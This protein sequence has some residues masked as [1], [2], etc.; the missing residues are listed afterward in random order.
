MTIPTTKN[1]QTLQEAVQ[2]E[3]VDPIEAGEAAASDFDIDRLTEQMIEW[4]SVHDEDGN[5]DLNCSG[6]RPVE[7]FR[8][9]LDDGTEN[10]D[11]ETLFWDAVVAAMR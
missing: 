2:R 4:H 10:P 11:K 9:F 3:I 8:D 6:Y 7:Q 1:Y 5:V